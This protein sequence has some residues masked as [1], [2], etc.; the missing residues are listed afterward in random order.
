ME[1]T[2]VRARPFFR[3]EVTPRSAELR[4]L[5]ACMESVRL[6][7]NRAYTAFNMADDE[8]WVEAC[9]YEINS[10][11]ARYNYLVKQAKWLEE[12]P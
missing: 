10:L 3:R 2:A 6:E 9:V 7:L 12:E 8:D 5:Q 11:Q 1:Q 4:Q